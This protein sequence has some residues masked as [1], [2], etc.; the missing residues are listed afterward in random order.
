MDFKLFYIKELNFHP[1]DI[2]K[3]QSSFG[4]IFELFTQNDI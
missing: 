1:K 4:F 2:L 3:F